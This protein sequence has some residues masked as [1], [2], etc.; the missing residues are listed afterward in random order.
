MSVVKDI[1]IS[2]KIAAV[3][4]LG[5]IA[6]GLGGFII[7]V[8]AAVLLILFGWA[9][10]LLSWYF[11]IFLAAIF[12]WIFFRAMRL[13]FKYSIQCKGNFALSLKYSLLYTILYSSWIYAIIVILHYLKS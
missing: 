5:G 9:I 10:V 2:Q 6:E 13:V 1:A 12:Y 8:F 11:V 7:A 4:E 3:G